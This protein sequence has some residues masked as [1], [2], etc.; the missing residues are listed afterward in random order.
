MTQDEL[1]THA[2]ELILDHAR[3]VEFLSVAEYLA[4]EQV[5]D[6]ND[7]IARRIHD[8]IHEA[9]IEVSFPE[10]GRG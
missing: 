7:D 4:D 10:A 3:D 6:P 9:T 5:D 2:I 8:L 1:Q